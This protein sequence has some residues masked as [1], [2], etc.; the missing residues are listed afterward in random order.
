MEERRGSNK[1]QMKEES[2]EMNERE[3]VFIRERRKIENDPRLKLKK[4]IHDLKVNNLV[5]NF[6]RKISM[7]NT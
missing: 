6:A 7:N 2:E 1:K 3:K 5:N 4:K